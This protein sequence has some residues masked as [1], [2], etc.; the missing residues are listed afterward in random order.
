MLICNGEADTFITADAIKAFRAALDGAKVNY[1]FVNYKDAVHSFT[2][3]D[4]DKAGMNKGVKYDK[5]ADADSWKHARDVR[6]SRTRWVDNGFGTR[7][8]RV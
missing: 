2:V 3:A 7:K 5:A 8:S 1:E 6:C 4:A